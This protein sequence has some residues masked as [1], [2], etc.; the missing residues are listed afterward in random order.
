MKNHGLSSLLRAA[1]PHTV[2]VLTGY[3]CM[4]AAMG[5]L[6]AAKGFHP[7]WATLMACVV[8]AG[9]AQFVA[10]G[11][12]AAGF[13][14]LAM[15][16][17]T[18][19][20]NARHI[21]YGLTSIERFRGFGRY[22]PYVIF[23]LTDETY[24]L[25]NSV[26]IP[27]GIEERKFLTAI[28]ALNQSYWIVGCTLGAFLGARIAFDV[29]GIDFVMTALFVVILMQ[30]LENPANRAPALIGFVLAV[31]CRLVFGSEAFIVSTMLAML[32]AFTLAR[33]TLQKQ[34]DG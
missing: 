20:V 19:M 23:A 32:A 9:S 15:L 11:L 8:Y 24:A 26:K 5:I 28:A 33:S 10:V 6:L 3:L 17:T 13:D 29:T 16:V 30:Q 27:D 25:F 7:L 31:V 2:P 1:F 4:G 34:A 22:R 12:L 14:P 21:F 18:L